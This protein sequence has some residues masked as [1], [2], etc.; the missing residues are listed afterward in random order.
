MKKITLLLSVFLLTTISSIGQVQIGDVTITFGEKIEESRGKIVKII[1]EVSN[2]IYAL[3][4]QGKKKYFINTFSSESM[5]LIRSVPLDLPEVKD[6]DLDFE[7]IFLI[8][9][10]VYVF[11]SV[12]H[13]KEKLSNL[14]AVEVLPDGRL[15]NKEKILFSNTADKHSERGSYYFRNASTNGKFF[16]MHVSFIKKPTTAVYEIKLFDE[17][18][19]QQ[20]VH[21]KEVPF[22]RQNNYHFGIEDFYL[23]NSDDIYIVINES[24]RDKKLKQQIE[25]F[26][27]HVYKKHKNYAE[28]IINLDANGNLIVNCHMM[29]GRDDVVQLV[30]FYSETNDRGRAK[31]QL[32]GVYNIN[33]NTVTN[34]VSNKKFNEFDYET[35]AKILGERRANKG[36]DLNPQYR[37]EYIVEREDGGIIVLSE[38]QMLSS[39][40]GTG[41]GPLALTTYTFQFNEI[42]ITAMDAQGNLEW[43]NVVPKDQTVSV[44]ELSLFFASFGVYSA[45]F[46]VGSGVVILLAVMGKGPEFISF[47]P[48]Y[49]NGRLSILFN[50]NDKNIGETNIDKIKQMKNF[51]KSV[52]VVFQF[53]ENG[54]M[55]RIDAETTDENRLII[56]P[57]VHR[58]IFQDEYILYSSRGKEEKLARMT[59]GL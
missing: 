40:S 43:S 6:K 13:R 15:S 52:P 47:I 35:K 26:E 17:L 33:I 51:N 36:K 25:N 14:V 19:E 45:G 38:M 9:E 48:I 10:K 2:Q 44:S 58:R 4:L 41:I 54:K 16:A 50:D 22:E 30:G 12:Y 32:K 3:S 8:G 53:D 5:E 18:L 20:M 57:Q 42:I 39:A 59:I 21:K 23:S 29:V 1:G 31:K 34:N 24:Y 55:L 11:G 49:E 7:E 28:E 46:Y 37:V 56:R 27:V